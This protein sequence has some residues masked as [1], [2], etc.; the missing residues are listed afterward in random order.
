MSADTFTAITRAV[1]R[2]FLTF[3]FFALFFYAYIEDGS[4]GLAD[5][6]SWLT[7]LGAAV[8]L[9]WYTARPLEKLYDRILADV[10]SRLPPAEQPTVEPAIPVFTTAGQ[11]RE[12]P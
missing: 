1:V 9:S 4:Q 11:P 6:P 8:I 12:E 10:E 2:P 3:G 5:L 7:A